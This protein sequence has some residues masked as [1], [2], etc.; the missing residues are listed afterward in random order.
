[1]EN[2]K[3]L[4]ELNDENNLKDD[5]SS[6][7]EELFVTKK[8]DGFLKEFFEWTQAI[9]VAVVLA[10]VINQFVFSVVEVQ[11]ASME[12]TLNQ[13]ER[14][15]VFKTFYKPKNKDIVIIKSEQL[16]KYIVK[17]VIATEGQIIDVDEETGAVYVDGVLQEE[18]YIKDDSN[19]YIGTTG[20]YPLEVPENHV[21]VMGDNRAN[22]MDSRVLGVINNEEIMGKAVFRI[23]PFDSFGGLYN[24]LD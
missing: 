5:A 23:W 15:F 4:D 9:A 19:F 12:P 24:N 13:S 18:P 3:V 8:K 22:S 20:I 11:G 7:D 14:L 10:L 2:E 16:G 21:F 6:D 1:M 17:R